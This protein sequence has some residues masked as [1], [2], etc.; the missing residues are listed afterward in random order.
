MIFQATFTACPQ[1]ITSG[2]ALSCSTS[3]P[4][5]PG[6][7]G[8]LAG[9]EWVGLHG[10][11]VPPYPLSLPNAA[12]L[13]TPFVC[14]ENSSFFLF[15]SLVLSQSLTPPPPQLSGSNEAPR[16][17][18][19]DPLQHRA[20]ASGTLGPGGY[21]HSYE[22]HTKRKMFDKGP[23]VCKIPFSLYFVYLFHTCIKYSTLLTVLWLKLIRNLHCYIQRIPFACSMIS[24]IW[25][26]SDLNATTPKHLNLQILG[27]KAC[28]GWFLSLVLEVQIW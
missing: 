4:S 6:R 11:L 20:S 19:M 16:A 5:S 18:K 22:F 23:E 13:S 21:P 24:H 8:Y 10:L 12:C 9:S 14:S 1:K 3:T 26:T 28:T 7:F 15:P 25:H 27:F 17:M 2:S